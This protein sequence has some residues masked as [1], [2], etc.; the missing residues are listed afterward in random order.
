MRWAWPGQAPN[1]LA[2]HHLLSKMACCLAI[3]GLP[4]L[5]ESVAVLMESARTSRSTIAP[6]A[7]LW[8][9]SSRLAASHWQGGREA[10]TPAVML[11]YCW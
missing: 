4:Q 9:V 7:L 2:L 3:V 8:S 11:I 10:K 5:A 6:P 1:P